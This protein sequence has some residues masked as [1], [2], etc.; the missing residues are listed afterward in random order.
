MLHCY[1]YRRLKPTL[2][3]SRPRL[4][5]NLIGTTI[6][7]KITN[8]I[9]NK[10]LYRIVKKV[11]IIFLLVSPLMNYPLTLSPAEVVFV[12]TLLLPS[13]RRFLAEE[14]LVMVSTEPQARDGQVTVEPL[15]PPAVTFCPSKEIL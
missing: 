7:L 9:M 3:Q 15:S 6:I 5:F 2:L 4:C 10:K 14:V 1:K 12:F 8:F 13:V 11:F